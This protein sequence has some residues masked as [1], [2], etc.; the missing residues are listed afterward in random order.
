[1]MNLCLRPCQQVV[2]EEEYRTEIARVL[3]FLRSQGRS[4]LETLV[5]ARDRLSQECDFEEA[6][7]QHKRILKIEETLRMRGELAADLEQLHGVAVTPAAQP[8]AVL[9]WFLIRGC[10]QPPRL[11]DC[12]PES[13]A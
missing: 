5:A 9:L 7:R 4:L 8:G 3:A 6:A 2:T 1:E 12:R 10:W 13:A 11:L